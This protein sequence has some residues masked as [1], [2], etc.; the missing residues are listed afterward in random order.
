MTASRHLDAF[1][2][3]IGTIENPPYK[4]Q[5]EML[6]FLKENGFQVSP[7][8]GS[9]TGRE[10]LEECIRQIEEK[11][12]SLDW[13][14]DGVVIKIG[15]STLREQMGFTEKFPRWA[16][17]YKFEAE[18]AVTKLSG[19]RPGS[20]PMPSRN[21]GTQAAKASE[22]RVRPPLRADASRGRTSTAV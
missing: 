13:L 5:P 6:A 4:T 14:I 2:Y 22:A 12:S 15:D 3:Q 20:P 1:F 7:Y 16:V 8:L 19:I 17:A 11:R 10:E 18:E 21:T 9:G